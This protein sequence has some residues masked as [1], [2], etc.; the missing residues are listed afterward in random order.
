MTNGGQ[1]AAAR[2]SMVIVVGTALMLIGLVSVAT[3]TAS[4][5]RPLFGAGFKGTV[6]GRQVVFV[7]A[8]L[9]IMAVT[10]RLAGGCLRSHRLRRWGVGL[11][12]VVTV[13]GLAAALV[14]GIAS[15]QGGSQRW[16]RFVVGG[17][18]LGLQPSELAKVALVMLVAS[19]LTRRGVDPRSLRDGFLPASAAIGV[20]VLLVGMEDFGTAVL[21]AASGGA[22]LLVAGCRVRDLAVLGVVGV[23][24]LTVLLFAEPYRLERIAAYLDFGGDPQ[25]AGYQPLQSLATIASGGWWGTGLGLG[26]QKYGYLP[27]SHTDFIF[28]VICEE[29]GA[30]GGMA[31][32]ALFAL[33]VWLGLRTMQAALSDFERLLAFGLTATLGLQT[34]MNVAVVTA[35]VPTTG[36]SLPLVSVG[37]SGV[38]TFSFAL[39]LLA[40]IARATEPR[41]AAPEHGLDR[42][43]STEGVR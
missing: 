39:G 3:A 11:L 43:L 36:I 4:L 13:G 27:A 19:M 1:N 26:V 24:G 38:L 6:L 35:L 21:L 34:V 5:D 30:L 2:S 32:L 25:G 31:V 9:T 16:L 14:P 29:M 8:G 37:G 7:L 40:A 42:S 12:F 23:I 10:S 18:Q 28:A 15:S 22:M 20:I 17:F 41:V 33:L